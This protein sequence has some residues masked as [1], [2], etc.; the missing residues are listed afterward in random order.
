M[1][2]LVSAAKN[3]GF[4]YPN[5]KIMAPHLY[6]FF[7]DIMYLYLGKLHYIE[8]DHL[9]KRLEIFSNGRII[10]LGIS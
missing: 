8:Y 6:N 7:L 3:I 9:V 1:Q 2:C 4:R 10:F 5:M